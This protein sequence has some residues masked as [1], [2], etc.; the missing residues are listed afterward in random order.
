[1]IWMTTSS[2]LQSFKPNT[3]DVT[4][5]K[6]FN[7]INRTSVLKQTA[8]WVSIPFCLSYWGLVT[9]VSKF[10]NGVIGE[11]VV[12]VASSLEVVFCGMGGYIT[13]GYFHRLSLFFRFSPS[14]P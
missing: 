1:M 4:F 5:L 7:F 2:L 8:G 13:F 9:V 3:G 12:G 11:L 10:V 14:F 6:P